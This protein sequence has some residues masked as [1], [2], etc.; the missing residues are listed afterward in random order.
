MEDDGEND[1]AQDLDASMEDLDDEGTADT[2]D[3][4]EL[5]EGETEEYEED[6]DASDTI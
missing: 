2:E 6:L 4:D 5:I 3:M 1:S